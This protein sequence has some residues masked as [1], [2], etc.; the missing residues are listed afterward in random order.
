MASAMA[1]A[2]AAALAIAAAAGGLASCSSAPK[3]P[4]AVYDTRNKAA[5]YAKLGDG[6]MATAQYELAE[7]YYRE[8]LQADSSVDNLE[9]VSK[10]HTSLARAYL[11]AGKSDEARSQ[12][13]SALDYGRM[14]GS[15]PASSLATSGLGEVAYRE[16]DK[17]GALKL[18][19]GAVSLAGADGSSLAVALHDEGVVKAALGR[20]PE[21][22]AD[23]E[24][25][26]SINLGLKRWIELAANRYVMASLL[27]SGNRLEEASA[28][29]LSALDADKRAE[30]G[31]GIAGDLAALA[32]LATRMDRKAEAW[33]Y[34]R[35]CFDSALA[36]GEPAEVRT[37]L[38]A[39][40]A[41]ADGL[42]KT[43]EK[44]RYAALL[45]KLDAARKAELNPGR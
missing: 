9:G 23:L 41:L 27:A 38:T 12:F 35:R 13:A 17:E 40:V 11:A 15:G 10:S 29:A 26:A 45:A 2:L 37:A 18:F 36:N 33:D 30:N 44:E 20:K 43:A 7:K 4:D 14:A 32:S 3:A 24:R 34:W 16:G 5:D 25:A 22:M 1:A 8:A 19:E 31:R 28:M 39:L 6:F 21:A 42:G